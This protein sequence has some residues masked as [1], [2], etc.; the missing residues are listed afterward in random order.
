LLRNCNDEL[1]FNEFPGT[2]NATIASRSVR[3]LICHSRLAFV[4]G[5]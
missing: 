3:L 2:C 5:S 1:Q 4:W